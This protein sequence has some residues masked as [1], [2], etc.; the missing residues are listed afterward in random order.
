MLEYPFKYFDYE[1]D[2]DEDN[3]GGLGSERSYVIIVLLSTK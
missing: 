2:E 1:E 3:D